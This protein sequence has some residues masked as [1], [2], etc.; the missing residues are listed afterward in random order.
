[1]VRNLHG[2]MDPETWGSW[3]VKM[4][5]PRGVWYVGASVRQMR[6]FWGLNELGFEGTDVETRCGRDMELLIEVI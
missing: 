2:R 3:E 5:K 1:M 4:W 6:Y